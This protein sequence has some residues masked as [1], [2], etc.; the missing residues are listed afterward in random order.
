MDYDELFILGICGVHVPGFMKWLMSGFINF[1]S[2]CSILV[3]F[4][5]VF[6][7]TT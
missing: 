5:Y 1:F 4:G 6:L 7:P 3:D 2:V